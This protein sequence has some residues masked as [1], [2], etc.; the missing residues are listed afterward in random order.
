MGGGG[1]TFPPSEKNPRCPIKRV[2]QWYILAAAAAIRGVGNSTILWASAASQLMSKLTTEA[3]AIV[4]REEVLI[5]KHGGVILIPGRQD[6]I[7]GPAGGGCSPHLPWMWLFQ[8]CSSSGSARLT[9]VQMSSGRLDQNRFDS[10]SFPLMSTTCDRKRKEQTCNLRDPVFEK[11]HK[12]LDGKMTKSCQENV[13]Q[14][15]APLTQVVHHC[16]KDL[17]HVKKKLKQDF[18][19]LPSILCSSDSS[20]TELGFLAWLVPPTDSIWAQ[21][22]VCVA[23][24]RE[25]KLQSDWTIV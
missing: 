2:A 20:K 10:L 4:Q 23:G 19:Q 18:D 7:S 9:V 16:A 13:S 11:T 21:Q 12:Q 15:K 1:H 25:P 17:S 14:G 5:C 24:Q 6:A 22:D 3:A 8:H